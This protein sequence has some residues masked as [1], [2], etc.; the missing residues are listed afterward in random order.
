VSNVRFPLRGE[1]GFPPSPTV[2]TTGGGIRPSG[3]RREPGGSFITWF[4]FFHFETAWMPP[5]LASWKLPKKLH[6]GL[7]IHSSYRIFL[8]Q[9]LMSGLPIASDAPEGH[10]LSV[11]WGKKFE[12]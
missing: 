12:R 7:P 4:S 9:M 8:V 11:L 3:F 1:R 5:G 6:D 10:G 2:F